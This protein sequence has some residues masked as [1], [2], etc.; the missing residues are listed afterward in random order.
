MGWMP[1]DTYWFHAG[2][3]WGA[4]ISAWHILYCCK[5]S[6]GQFLGQAAAVAFAQTN[7]ADG[8]HTPGCDCGRW[9]QSP[10]WNADTI[11]S[12]KQVKQIVFTNLFRIICCPGESKIISVAKIWWTRLQVKK[13]WKS[14]V[15]S[16]DN[17]HC[18]QCKV[19]LTQDLR[20]LDNP[21]ILFSIQQTTSAQVVLYGLKRVYETT[22][23]LSNAPQVFLELK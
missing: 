5:N 14:E 13:L 19:C 6:K 20:D 8:G 2:G 18:F 9:N 17:L 15:N 23:F 1:Y 11:H 4:S 16:P 10:L 7:S 3:S 12:H 22:N 21:L